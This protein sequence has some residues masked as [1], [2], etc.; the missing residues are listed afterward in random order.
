MNQSRG[1]KCAGRVG[2]T[3][4]GELIECHGG[5]NQSTHHRLVSS[6]AREAVPA[7]WIARWTVEWAGLTESRSG[8]ISGKPFVHRPA[9]DC[10]ADR[11]AG[12]LTHHR[13]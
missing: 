2:T 8:G 13:S 12:H 10:P 7:R 6:V 5:L 9:T 11:L 1:R 3:L 4:R